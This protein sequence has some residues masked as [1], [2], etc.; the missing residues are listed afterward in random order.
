MRLQYQR[1]QCAQLQ[2]NLAFFQLA[3][4]KVHAFDVKQWL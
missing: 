1:R 3:E 2:G 4:V